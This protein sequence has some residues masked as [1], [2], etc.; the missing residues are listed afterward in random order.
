M[1][2][3]MTKWEE[4]K[5]GYGLEEVPSELRKEFICC[6]CGVDYPRDKLYTDRP[7]GQ[8]QTVNE[9]RQHVEKMRAIAT[10]E[11]TLSGFSLSKRR[12]SNAR[13]RFT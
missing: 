3:R 2:K 7:I 6:L 1:T 10:V 8:Y 11:C 4:I 12:M 5:E 9:Y 13:S